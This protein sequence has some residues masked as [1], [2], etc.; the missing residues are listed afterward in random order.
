MKEELLQIVDSNGEPVGTAKRCEC[1]RNP[2]LI[3][4]VVHIHIFDN[5]GRLFLQQRAKTKDLFPEYW[6]TS[7]GGHISAGETVIH[8]MIREGEE[9]LGI[10]T[11]RAVFRF[12]YLWKN[13]NETEYVHSFSLRYDG[14]MKL[15][16]KEINKGQFFKIKEIKKMFKTESITPNFKYEFYLLKKKC[17]I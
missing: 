13:E 14:K 15:N 11:G 17:I 4:P 7:V 5:K 9:E 12:N 1:H 16:Y 3:H 10:D 8:A 6:D 2:S